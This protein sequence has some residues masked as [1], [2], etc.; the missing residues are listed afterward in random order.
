MA[1]A[2]V[3]L[4]SLTE[5]PRPPPSPFRLQL[6]R[7]LCSAW[8]LRPEWQRMLRPALAVLLCDDDPGVREAAL[9]HLHGVLPGALPRRL[10]VGMRG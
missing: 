7:L 9:Q 6:L 3:I 1:P 10:Q 2:G 4:P 8:P 5:C